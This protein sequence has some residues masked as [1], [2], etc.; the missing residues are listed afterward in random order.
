MD[1]LK[2]FRPKKKRPIRRFSE[3]EIL[4]YVKEQCD[5]SWG[6]LR[7]LDSGPYTIGGKKS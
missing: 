1:L 6:N 4:Q 3:K 2:W 5:A 7:E